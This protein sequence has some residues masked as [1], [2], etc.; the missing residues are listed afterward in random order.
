M[1][2]AIYLEHLR[3]EDSRR[4]TLSNQQ[5]RA[6][7]RM[8]REGQSYAELARIFGCS[9]QHI[10]NIVKWRVRRKDGL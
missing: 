6:I 4:A 1:T 10:C 2:R 8:Y 3:G 7:R 9:R 5:V